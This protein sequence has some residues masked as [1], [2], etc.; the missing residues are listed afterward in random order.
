MLRTRARDKRVDIEFS[1]QSFTKSDL[2]PVFDIVPFLLLENAIKYSPK[3]TKIVVTFSERPHCID[4]S[5]DSV[6]PLVEDH[7]RQRLTEKNFRGECARA[8]GI[9]GTGF[10][11]HFAKY[12]C[13]LNGITFEISS[14]ISSY[15]VNGVPHAP[16]GVTL[17]VPRGQI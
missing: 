2:Y 4:V 12:V 11:L 16:F 1:G 17:K 15:S 8:L 5:I 13:D 3:E 6:G 14:S 7:E 9:P 10:G